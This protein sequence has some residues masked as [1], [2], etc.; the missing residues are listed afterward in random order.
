[1]RWIALWAGAA[2]LGCASAPEIGPGFRAGSGNPA[3]FA[4]GIEDRIVRAV[5]ELVRD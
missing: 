1:M 4:A 5:L 3:P 2:C